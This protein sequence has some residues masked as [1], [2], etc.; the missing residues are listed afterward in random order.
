MFPK[1]LTVTIIGVGSIGIQP[2]VADP[3]IKSGE[4]VDYFVQAEKLGAARGICI[5][6]EQEC[7]KKAPKPTGLDML[8]N[9]GLDSA[10]LTPEAQQILTSL[11]KPFTA[12][13][14]RAP[15]LLSKATRMPVGPTSTTS[16]SRNGGPRR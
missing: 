15:V 7:D 1:F 10:T 12:T 8:I 11:P 6:T 3:K 16:A 5:G 13:S 9:F 14:L 2:A 4:I